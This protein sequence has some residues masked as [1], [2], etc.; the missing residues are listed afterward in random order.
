MAGTLKHRDSGSDRREANRTRNLARL[1]E[2][3]LTGIAR[4]RGR[5]QTIGQ[6]A[7]FKGKMLQALHSIRREAARYGYDAPEFE[8]AEFA[9]VAFLDETVLT[10]NDPS[11]DE[12]RESTFQHEKYGISNAGDKFFERLTARMARSDSS[13]LADVLEV[14]LLC[15][16][17][18]FEGRHAGNP[19]GELQRITT[20]LRE[21]VNRIRGGGR[22]LSPEGEMVA[23]PKAP[24]RGGLD[25][26]KMLTI[27]IISSVAVFL[28]WSAAKL[29]LSA[30]SQEAARVI[31]ETR[32][33]AASV[34]QGITREPGGTPR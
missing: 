14:Y 33:P 22:E 17:L 3:V 16:L 32:G 29:H 7:V 18:G 25:L 12:W 26:R 2:G 6:P 34:E 31:L 4:I 10:S 28:T 30:T 21:R 20:E 24:A 15:L 5:R 1:C 27:F 9:L 13:G 23:A 8:D 19:N 11:A